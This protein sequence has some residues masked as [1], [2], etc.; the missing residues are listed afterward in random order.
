[1]RVVVV[2]PLL[3]PPLH[4]QHPQLLAYVLPGT[5]SCLGAELRT[6]G[7]S[8]PW[9]SGSVSATLRDQQQLNLPNYKNPAYVYA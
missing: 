4:H 7:P 6:L 1:M 3:P 9:F 8:D 5:A 2:P